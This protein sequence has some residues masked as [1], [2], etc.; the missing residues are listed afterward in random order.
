MEYHS[1]AQKNKLLIQK[2]TQVGLEGIVSR[3]ENQ[4]P[5]QIFTYYVIL[6][7]KVSKMAKWQCWRVDQEFW[8]LHV[9]GGTALTMTQKDKRV[10]CGFK[11]SHV[12]RLH[13]TLPP[14][15][16]RHLTLLVNYT[17]ISLLNWRILSATKEEF[18]SGEITWG[19]WEISP[20]LQLPINA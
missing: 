9:R 1:A 6:F 16:L 19:F 20:L 11:N 12:L 4:R 2:T 3:G 14:K 17:L 15:A 7:V 8:K 13:R 18:T 5:C 10:R